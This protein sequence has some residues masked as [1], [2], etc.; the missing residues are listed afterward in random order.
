[1]KT[2]GS[3]VTLL[4]WCLTGKLILKA[5]GNYKVD[6]VWAACVDFVWFLFGA[7]NMCLN[8]VNRL[9][10]TKNQN[11]LSK[12]P[13]FQCLLENCPTRSAFYVVTRSWHRVV[14]APSKRRSLF[15]LQSPL[16]PTALPASGF[17]QVCSLTS[18]CS[19]LIL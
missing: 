6:N 16:L 12:K 9:S 3:P 11:T 14:A 17:M 1:M 8:N 18:S 7:L 10:T 19:P 5:N 4:A 15:S 2:S 13:A